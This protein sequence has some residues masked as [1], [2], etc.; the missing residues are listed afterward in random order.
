MAHDLR[1]T[2]SPMYT[3]LLDCLLRLLPRPISAPALTA[4]LETFSSLFK[5]LLVPLTDL[6]YLEQTWSS[7]CGILPKCLPEVQ[8]AMAE[9]WG[10]VLRKLKVPVRE[11]AVL[12]LARDV[13]GIKDAC[14]WSLVFACKV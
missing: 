6:E 12:L 8:R 1:T 10:A 3:D 7:I 14:A 9:V 2:L 5:Y 4:L 11:K 13:K